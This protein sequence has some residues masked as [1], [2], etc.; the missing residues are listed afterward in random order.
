MKTVHVLLANSERRTNNLIEVALR[1]VCYDHALVQCAF[2][3]RLD[4]ALHRGSSEEFSM[5]FLAPDHLVSGPPQ[6]ASRCSTRDG[7]AAIRTLKSRRSVPIVAVGV[8][9]HDE[10]PLLEAGADRVF[11]VLFD[12]D[13]LRLETRRLLHLPEPV[14]Q[15]EPEATRWS[16]GAGLLRTFQKLRQA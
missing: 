7:A 8:R 14:L 13:S 1:D 4:E 15:P 9:P 5:I 16:F 6:R 10:L 12:S 2:T 3:R 11:G